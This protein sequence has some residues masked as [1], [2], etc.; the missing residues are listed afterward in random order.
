MDQPPCASQ[1]GLTL[2]SPLGSVTLGSSLSDP[3]AGHRRL[4]CQPLPLTRYPPGCDPPPPPRAPR[5]KSPPLSSSCPGN[6]L[7]TPPAGTRR[8]PS[9]NWL[10]A[11]HFRSPSEATSPGSQT[12]IISDATHVCF[13]PEVTRCRQ[14]HFPHGF[15]CILSSPSPPARP[16]LRFSSSAASI[17]TVFLK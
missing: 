16:S 12:P 5:A 8:F 13:P 7:Q 3:E 10:L 4:H 15:T 1:A 14:S 11:P 9:P 17:M 2:R 6:V